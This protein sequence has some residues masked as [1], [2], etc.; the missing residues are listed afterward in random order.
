M[1]PDPAVRVAVLLHHYPLAGVGPPPAGSGPEAR[2]AASTSDA[3]TMLARPRS[4]R[5]LRLGSVARPGARPRAAGRAQAG[6]HVGWSGRDRARSEA[7]T[8][9]GHQQSRPSPARLPGLGAGPGPARPRLCAWPAQPP[10]QARALRRPA[11]DAAAD[12]PQTTARCCGPRA[13]AGA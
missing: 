1:S 11:V 10:G 2:T 3:V 7:A 5:A 9:G 13:G 12:G 8:P 6:H 4:Q